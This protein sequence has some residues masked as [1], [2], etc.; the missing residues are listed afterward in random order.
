LTQTES[1]LEPEKPQDPAPTPT[2]QAAAPAAKEEQAEAP[3]PTPAKPAAPKSWASIISAGHGAKPPVATPAVPAATSTSAPRSQPK[4]AQQAPAQSAPPSAPVAATPSS[5][6]AS[7][8]EDQQDAGWQ[9]AGAEHSRKQSRAQAQVPSGERRSA[10]VRAFVKN[11]YPSVEADALKSALSKHG[12]IVYFD[13]S[14]PKNCAFV[15]FASMADFNAAVQANPHKVG[16]DEV[17][18]EERLER[19]DGGPRPPQFQRGGMRGGRGGS[20]RGRGNFSPRGGRGGAPAPARGGR[21]GA[22]AA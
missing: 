8:T 5:R 20:D 12:E 10:G 6:D 14:R 21:G 16:S 3:A 17:V 11:V 2:P 18:V 1:A 7:A 19:R 13:V 4:P 22:Q 9:T 15:E